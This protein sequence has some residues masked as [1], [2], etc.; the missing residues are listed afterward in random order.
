MIRA[1]A[2]GDPRRGR[3]NARPE[4]GGLGRGPPPAVLEGLGRAR[5]IARV[6]RKPRG[7]IQP[8]R[9]R[10]FRGTRA[11]GSGGPRE[12]RRGRGGRSSCF[13]P[14]RVRR[15]DV[16]LG[17]D[18][19]APPRAGSGRLSRGGRDRARAKSDERSRRAVGR[20][21]HGVLRPLADV[22]LALRRTGRGL[23]R[24]LFRRP[25]AGARLVGPQFNGARRT[26]LSQSCGQAG[27][28]KVAAPQAPLRFGSR[29]GFHP[30][31]REAHIKPGEQGRGPA[32]RKSR[33]IFRR[34]GGVQ[35]TARAV[36]RAACSG[37]SVGASGFLRFGSMEFQ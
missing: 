12:L 27:K 33:S 34:V 18:R 14:F 20:A 32:A 11:Q 7:A 31:G 16:V 25:G 36:L 9:R 3:G 22:S 5:R 30:G 13:G 28:A 26:I 29:N 17:I 37:L 2:R 10:R 35:S 24:R 21:A 1:E 8:G 23:R 19:S 6:I 4:P 15:G